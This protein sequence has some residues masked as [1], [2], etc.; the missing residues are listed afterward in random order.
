MALFEQLVYDCVEFLIYLFDS[1]VLLNQ[2][3]IYLVIQKWLTVCSTVYGLLASSSFLTGCELLA[4]RL[5]VLWWIH[6]I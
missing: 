1:F 4:I 3:Y 2:L 5:K 6:C